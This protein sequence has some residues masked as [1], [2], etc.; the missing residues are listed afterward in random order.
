MT[1]IIEQDELPQR[2]MIYWSIKIPY[3]EK[4]AQKLLINSDV[5]AD[6]ERA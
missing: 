4:G 3:C 2:N 5:T 6:H 1:D